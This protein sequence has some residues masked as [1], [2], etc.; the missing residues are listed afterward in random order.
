MVAVNQT[1]FPRGAQARPM[2]VTLRATVDL[3][4]PRRRAWS[5]HPSTTFLTNQPPALTSRA[6]SIPATLDRVVQKCLAK[7]PEQRWQSARD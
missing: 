4:P 6:G 5:P 7:N 1:S 2:P 3:R